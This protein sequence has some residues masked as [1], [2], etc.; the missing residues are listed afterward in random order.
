MRVYDARV[1]RGGWYIGDFTPSVFRTKEFE[2]C[3]KHHPKD[4]DWPDHY[5]AEAIEIN[6][7]ISGMM[8][9]NDMYIGPGAIFV[10]EPFEVARPRFISDCVVVVVKVPS[11]PGDKIEVSKIMRDE[12]IWT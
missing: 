2:V 1:M 10:F 9:V 4:E 12:E 6:Y 7:L 8:Q 11:I 3:V 5:H